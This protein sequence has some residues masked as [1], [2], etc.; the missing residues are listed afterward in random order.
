MSDK[1]Q[2]PA[3]LVIRPRDIAFGRNQ[4]HSR[5]WLGG[6]PVATAFYNTL[7]GAFPQ[8]ERFFIESVRYFK[9]MVSPKLKDQI[10]A[11]ATQEFIHTREHLVFNRQA[12]DAGYDLSGI[13][14]YVGKTLK[15]ARS[16][17]RYQ[18]LAIT[19]ALEHFTAIMAHAILTDARHFE[20][21]SE[22]VQRMWRWHAMEEIEH[23]AVAFD[24]FCEV[25]HHWP[26]LRRWLMRS[27]VMAITTVLFLS[28]I[29][30]GCRES[31]Q[32]DGI[33]TPRTWFKLLHFMFVKP[34]M[35]R[36]V[37]KDYFSYYRPGFHPW[38]HDDRELIAE[39]D[40]ALTQQYAAA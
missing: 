40:T 23:K 33:D 27:I 38:D 15:F 6:D 9:G 21:A 31:F 13:E 17:G 34:G 22:E 16:R 8:G 39:M 29:F 11:F 19:T 18:Q 37:L 3:D 10:A 14:A 12:V 28:E 26:A 5:W 25:T 7:S 1:M 30:V 2:T 32:Q 35:M 20:G 36:R 4:A 24:T